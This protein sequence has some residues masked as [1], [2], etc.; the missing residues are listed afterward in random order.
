MNERRLQLLDACEAQAGG[1]PLRAS[2]ENEIS[3]LRLGKRVTLLG[4]VDYSGLPALYR[5]AD[6]YLQPSISEQWGLA[7]N[8]AMAS[9]LPIVVSTRCGCVEDLLEVGS[10]GFSFDPTEPASL[11][12]AVQRIQSCRDRWQEMGEASRARIDRWGL[13]LFAKSFLSAVE[14]AVERPRA[15]KTSDWLMA[16][17]A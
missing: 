9:G 16:M 1:G 7:V 15:R 12:E 14:M 4:H 13:S 11:V 5:Q 17:I 8:E 10:N 3:R 2:I 6:V